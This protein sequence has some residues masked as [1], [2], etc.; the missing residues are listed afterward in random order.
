MFEKCKLC[1][2]KL[3]WFLLITWL[4]KEPIASFITLRLF[5]IGFKL[6]REFQTISK[7]FGYLDLIEGHK[8]T[9]L[10]G[11]L[12]GKTSHIKLCLSKIAKYFPRVQYILLF[13]EFELQYS[14]FCFVMFV[15]FPLKHGITSNNKCWSK[16]VRVVVLYGNSWK[17]T[18]DVFS[19]IMCCDLYW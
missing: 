4:T 9:K 14:F 15:L 19:K 11:I 10:N 18:E 17:L 8:R 6:F 3:K 7:L 1:Q 5:R 12:F 13:G 16:K 2:F